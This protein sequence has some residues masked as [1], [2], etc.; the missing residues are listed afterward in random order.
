MRDAFAIAADL[1]I[2]PLQRPQ[3]AP[4]YDQATESILKSWE[5]GNFEECAGILD[6]FPTL[7]VEGFAMGTFL[8]AAIKSFDANVI[9]HL[10][11]LRLFI[12]A[13]TK[14]VRRS[15]VWTCALEENRLDVMRALWSHRKTH[16]LDTGTLTQALSYAARES[17]R[18]EMIAWLIEAGADISSVAAEDR[19]KYVHPLTFALHDA[20]NVGTEETVRAVLNLGADPNH[21]DSEGGVPLVWAACYGDVSKVRALLSHGAHAPSETEDA[22]FWQALELAPEDCVEEIRRSCRSRQVGQMLKEVMGEDPE[23]SGGMSGDPG[24][25]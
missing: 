11:N 24:P 18:S 1:H 21:R 14:D 3:S 5:E 10:I 16:A 17:Y 19:F 2:A 20:L 15:N 6:R 12:A 4:G 7:R 23:S 22:N 13:P 9:I 25:L 8:A